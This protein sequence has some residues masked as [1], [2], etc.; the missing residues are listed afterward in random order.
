MIRAMRKGSSAKPAPRTG[1][2]ASAL[3]ARANLQAL[4]GVLDVLDRFGVAAGPVLQAA[5]L[6]CDDFEDPDRSATFEQLDRLF[7]SAVERTGCGHFGLLVGTTYTLQSFGIAG[8]LARNAP[9][10]GAALRELTTYFALHDTGGTTNVAVRD[11]TATIAYG[12][13]AT[14]VRNAD[15]VYDLAVA[16]L[17]NIM[18]QLCGPNLHPDVILLPRRRPRDIHAYREVLD[19]PLRF[20]SMQAGLVLP[21]KWLDHPIADADPLLHRLIEDRA[22]AVMT[23]LDPLLHNEVR[24][25][26][27]GALMTGDCSRTEVARRLGLHP[28]TLVRRLQQSGTTFQALLDDT[29]SHIARQLL[30]DTRSPVSRIANSLGYRDPTVFTRA[31]RRWTGLTPRAFRAALPGKW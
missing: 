6:T 9:T 20:D 1:A 26:L 28:R 4:R 11:G 31:F 12:I 8:R 17:L 14:G 3:A 2:T 21:A 13:H 5:S 10:V 15:Q 22:T 29:R 27:R 19:A 18:R 16:A 23:Q 24:R 25:V 7:A 30:H